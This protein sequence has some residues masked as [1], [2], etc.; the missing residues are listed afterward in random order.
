MKAIPVGALLDAKKSMGT[1][2]IHY[3]F[4]AWLIVTSKVNLIGCVL[5]A[6]MLIRHLDALQLL[7]FDNLC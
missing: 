4:N 5:C 3:L 6:L 1:T 7:S 2:H